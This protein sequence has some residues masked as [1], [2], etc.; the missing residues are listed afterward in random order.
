MRTR[1]SGAGILM[2]AVA[3]APGV[4]AGCSCDSGG[5]AGSVFGSG[6][7]GGGHGSGVG[8]AGH[9][10]SNGTSTGSDGSFAEGVGPGGGG[11]G[12]VG[13]ECQQIVCENGGK[14]TVSG[15]VFEPAGTVGL[16]NVVVYVP[17]KPVD[18]I[19]DGASCDRCDATL[20]GS[21]IATA[22]TDTHGRF[23]LENVP[24]G[25]NIPLVVQVGKWR[26]EIVLPQV[27]AC[28]DN[29]AVDGSVRLARNQAEGHIPKIALAT[30]GA[31]PLECLLHKIGLDDSEFTTEAGT[32]RVNLFGGIGGTSQ[33]AAGLNGGAAFSPALNLWGSLDSLMHYDM[34]LLACEG[35]NQH[36]ENKPAAALQAMSDYASAGGRLFASHWHNIWLESGPGQLP[37]TAVWNHQ[38]DPS[39]PLIAAIDT[40]FPKGEAFSDWLLNVG[41]STQRGQISIRQPQHTVDS[42]NPA[43]STRWIYSV[44][45]A[46][47]GVQYFSFNTPIGVP[48]EEQCGRLVYTDI[49][50]SAEDDTNTPFPDGC[51]SG[52]LTPQEKALLFILFDLS[53]CV[54]PDDEPPPVPIPQ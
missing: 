10:G 47:P 48:N 42:V 6:G 15:T 24:V 39:D 25:T 46:T 23:V 52:A 37:E 29:P 5:S 16:Y 33:Y 40:T 30:G 51:S 13:L 36:P 17:N 35:S 22:L 12:C 14:T 8:G 21:P 1:L 19:A 9:G 34:V 41:A 53:S 28:V 44:P 49:H 27:E 32:G 54:S 38:D 2:A 18:P 31:D 26:R 11:E 20:S 45:P 43:I 4:I 7:S 50:I 3:V